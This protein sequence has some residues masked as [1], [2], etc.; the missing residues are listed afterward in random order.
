M[1]IEIMK[2]KLLIFYIFPVSKSGTY[3]AHNP[4][5][6][7]STLWTTR[8]E[9]VPIYQVGIKVKKKK[10]T[11]YFFYYYVKDQLSVA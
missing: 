4:S 11:L 8:S 2:P 5:T 10:I 9:D 7:I 1:C 3:G 6:C